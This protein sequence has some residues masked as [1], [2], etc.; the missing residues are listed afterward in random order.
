MFV[1]DR[2]MDTPL[3]IQD[4]TDYSYWVQKTN[5]II[6][7][8]SYSHQC[9][10][11]LLHSVVTFTLQYNH[12]HCNVHRCALTRQECYQ[13]IR[14]DT[15]SLLIVLLQT[16]TKNHAIKKHIGYSNKPKYVY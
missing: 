9:M 12:Y 14:F 10:R 1:E 7:M 2:K 8:T 3:T 5:N 13:S 4:E 11:G 15:I 16:K 6:Q